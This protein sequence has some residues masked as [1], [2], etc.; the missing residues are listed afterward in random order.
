MKLNRTGR[1]SRSLVLFVLSLGVFVMLGWSRPSIAV[2]TGELFASNPSTQ[3]NVR[4]SPSTTAPLA[5]IAFPGDQVQILSTTQSRDGFT[6][7]QMQSNRSGIVGWVRGDLVRPFGAVARR[8][9]APSISAAQPVVAPQPQ[10]FTPAKTAAVEKN[11]FIPVPQVSNCAPVYPVRPPV[12]NQ[13]FGRVS[14][15]FNARQSHFHTGIDFDGKIGTPINSP[16]CGT[17]F[18][19]GREQDGNSYEWGY[20]WHVKIRDSEGKIHLFAHISKA[21]V[22]VGQTVTS[23]QLIAAIGNNGN[24]TGPHLHYEIRQGADTYQSAINPMPFLALVRQADGSQAGL[25]L[26]TEY[27]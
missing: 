9:V 14:D 13:G 23:G 16:V 22:K 5:G 15:P 4:T 8:T 12:V 24:S 26:P 7:Y 27:R 21:Y 11:L 20:G 2:Q 1:L 18:Y 10:V 19:V 17:V 3:I 25:I 6:W